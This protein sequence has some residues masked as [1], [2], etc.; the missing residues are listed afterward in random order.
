MTPR[1][2]TF[3][4]CGC[5]I[6]CCCFKSSDQYS[7]S[8]VDQLSEC[9]ALF[10]DSDYVGSLTMERNAFSENLFLKEYKKKNNR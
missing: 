8:P 3:D 5:S 6:I 10:K 9:L 2:I 7:V 1:Y 4:L